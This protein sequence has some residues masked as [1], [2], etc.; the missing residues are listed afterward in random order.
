MPMCLMPFS[1][2]CK[3][4]IEKLYVYLKFGFFWV[5]QALE[6]ANQVELAQL[7]SEKSFAGAQ[8]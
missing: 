3:C 6:T 8:L 1:F 5:S 4:A 2:T 7:T